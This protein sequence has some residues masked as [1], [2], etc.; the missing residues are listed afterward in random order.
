MI[1]KKVKSLSK[2]YG[3]VLIFDEVTSGFRETLGGMYKK[4]DV[5]P[6]LVTFGKAISNGIPMSAPGKKNIMKS[7]N[8]HSLAAHIGETRTGGC[9]S[10]NRLYEKNN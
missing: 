9:F 4:T 8:P 6:D 2:K 10:N 3:A 5:V 1:S 7:F